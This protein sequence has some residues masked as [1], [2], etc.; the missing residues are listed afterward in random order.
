MRTL[1]FWFAATVFAASTIV[2]ASTLIGFDL[3]ERVPQLMFLH[4][5]AMAACF[6]ALA[7]MGRKFSKKGDFDK[8]LKRNAPS[9]RRAGMVLTLNAFVCFALFMVFGKL[10]GPEKRGDKFAVVSHG[11]VLRE[12]TEPQYH[13]LRGFEIRFF[14]SFWMLFSGYPALI[15][16]ATRR[17]PRRSLDPVG[18]TSAW[19]GPSQIIP[20]DGGTTAVFERVENE[21]Q[22]PLFKLF[23]NPEQSFS[24]SFT[25]EKLPADLRTLLGPA[26]TIDLQFHKSEQI[27]ILG[28]DGQWQTFRS[29]EE[30]PPDL[31]QLYEAGRQSPERLTTKVLLKL[32]DSQGGERTYHSLD[33]MPP[34]IRALFER[35]QSLRGD[36]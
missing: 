21:T 35:L 36:E 30:I 1:W 15:A 11:T 32:A 22:E 13:T 10:G 17:P 20:S 7:S 14:S 31:R 24:K 28:A 12:L 29:P 25:L 18:A 8:W 23:D 2:Y 19:N 5:F 26:D 16:A 4:L 34:E 9:S 6:A 27:T 33:E 3:V